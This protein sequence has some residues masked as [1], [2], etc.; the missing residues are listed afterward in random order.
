MASI[1][2]CDLPSMVLI[3][4]AISL[5]HFTALIGATKPSVISGEGT[6]ITA[7]K[8]PKQPMQKTAA[9]QELEDLL[10][11]ADEEEGR[12]VRNHRFSALPK[13]SADLCSARCVLV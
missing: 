10:K 1:L 9:A 8:T 4:I 3:L 12:K 7:Q 11:Q 6:A 13:D 2:A 5:I